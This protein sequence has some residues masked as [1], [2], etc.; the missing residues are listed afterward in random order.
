[1]VV[2][3]GRVFFIDGDPK[4]GEECVAVCLD[5][6]TG[7][8]LWRTDSRAYFKKTSGCSYGGGV[9]V[10]EVSAFRDRGTCF[11]YG[12]SGRD[13]MHLW[14]RSY[15]PSM[16]HNNQA[17][18]Y[19]LGEDLW[20]HENGFTM[21]DR[22]TGEKKRTVPGGG[23][24]CFPAIATVRYL[25]HG[26]M[27][28]TDPKTGKV[29]ANRIT[30]GGCAENPFIPANGLIYT[31][32]KHC[33]CFPML[34]G[35]CA[36]APASRTSGTRAWAEGGFDKGPA[37]GVSF[38]A[39][40][41]KE[42]QDEWPMYRHDRFRSGGSGALVHTRPKRLWSV[43]VVGPKLSVGGMIWDDWQHH[44]YAN[45]R[46]TPPVAAGGRVFL[47]IPHEHRVV[48]LEARTGKPLWGFTANG[49]VDLPPTIHR[50]L[51]LFG[52]RSGWVYCLVAHDG[53]MVWRLRASPRDKR[54]VACGELESAWPVPGSVLA[55]EGMVY[56]AAGR[57]P[58]ADGGVHVLTVRAATG[59]I[60][61]RGV[62]DSVDIDRWY[63]R[64]GT[65]YEPVDLLVFDGE[66]RIAMSRARFTPRRASGPAQLSPA[67]QKRGL[68]VTV[69]GSAGAF[70][71]AGASGPWVPVG[72]WAYGRS[73]RRQR[74]KR[75]L[76]VFRGETLYASD[77]A[78][79]AVLP[80]KHP[81]G[82]GRHWTPYNYLNTLKKK[83]IGG[84]KGLRAM[85][86][87]DEALFAV[88]GG[89]VLTAFSTDKG[90]KLSSLDLAGACAWD[91]M[92]AAYGRLYVSMRDG[93]IICLGD[94]RM[95]PP[96]FPT[97]ATPSSSPADRK[98]DAVEPGDDPA[99]RAVERREV[100]G[101]DQ[102]A[103]VGKKTPSAK[104][105]AAWDAKLLARVMVKHAA[106][107]GEIAEAWPGL[108][109]DDKASLALSVA[110]D[111]E[112]GHALAAFYL[113]ATG[114]EA[115]AGEHLRKAGAA[116][117]AVR[118]AFE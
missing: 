79:A 71:Q 9:L 78:V 40:P 69:D 33:I 14:T 39:R 89:G 85:V 105:I 17:R 103:P 113:I 23:G 110:G 32:P 106:A 115:E 100:S 75:Y 36:L 66:D 41:E 6:A 53:R 88:D 2:G 11:V 80:D 44:G 5:L 55:H 76:Y 96:P 65:D 45:D 24:H 42:T 117:E 81:G 73:M 34:Q 98:D 92:A 27:D 12:I 61:S 15:V 4:R 29:I 86:V 7:K 38:A 101:P 1:V 99:R 54:I 83:W 43:S 48:A 58:L 77:G 93:R 91:G 22:L 111:D 31:I 104:A 25:M 56:F 60:V 94:P 109:L 114:K 28:F 74:P 51:C 102:G 52:T 87:T 26:E 64:L 63:N 90:K 37:F 35:Y 57:H 3:D 82:G 50:G 59:K 47:A 10:C 8:E 97:R 67:A 18:A 21:L 13:G 107:A 84:V 112:A 118:A 95:P 16:G 20:L 62:V 68:G 19:F 46:I 108:S 49:I 70:H 72:I 116:A 30:K